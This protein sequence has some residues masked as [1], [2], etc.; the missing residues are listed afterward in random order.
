MSIQTGIILPLKAYVPLEFACKQL[1][2][3]TC[4]ALAGAFTATVLTFAVKEAVIAG[5]GVGLA[6]TAARLI[7]LA[8]QTERILS[9]TF[10]GKT[11]GNLLL[12]EKLEDHIRSLKAIPIIICMS[13]GVLPMSLGIVLTASVANYVFWNISEYVANQCIDH[14]FQAAGL[15][16]EI[17]IS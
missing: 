2:N 3:I 1:S 15:S 14:T 12:N 7:A 17:T 11:F 4:G 10:D 9:T 6:F 16:E 5:A 13:T 8:F